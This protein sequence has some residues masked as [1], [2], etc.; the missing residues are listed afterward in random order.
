MNSKKIKEIIKFD[1]E[2][3]IQNKWFM[4]LNIVIF[5]SILF[6]T[7][8]S[9]IENFLDKHDM[10]FME[11]ED[12]TIQVLDNDNILYGELEKHTS[13]IEAIKLEKVTENKYSKDN[14]PADDL[15]LIEAIKDETELIKIKLVSKEGIGSDVYDLI[16]ETVKEARNTLFAAKYNI[17]AEELGTLSSE[18]AIERI[19]LGVDAENSETKEL[20]K[21]VSIVLVYMV[22]IL[23]TSSIANT[24]AQEKTSKSIEYVLTS[25]TAKEYLLAK[26]LGVT[27]TIMVQ[28]LYTGIYYVIGNLIN[29]IIVM[30]SGIV[31]TSGQAVSAISNIDIDI[32]KYVLAMVAYLIFTVFFVALIQATLSS[33]T[34]S[35]SEAGNT[36]TLILFVIIFLYFISLGAITPYTNVSMFMYVISCLPIVSTFFV[37]AMMI[38]GQATTLQIVISFVVLILSVPLVFNICAKYFKNGILDYTSKKK[39]KKLFGKKEEKEQTL[40]EKQEYELKLKFAKRFSF[41]IGMTLILFIFSQTI[42]EMIL[43]IALPTILKDV[44]DSNTILIITT[45]L[46]STISMLI[47]IGFINLYN[48]QEKVKTKTSGKST[49]NLVGVGI[50]LIGLSQ[51]VLPYIYEFFGIN[52]NILESFEVIPGKGFVPGLIFFIVLAVLPAIFEELFCR[53]AILNCA[54]IYGNSFAVIFSAL[55]FAIIHMNFGQAI[56]AFMIGII[57]GV[58]AVKTNSIKIP[59][60]LHLLN[61]GYAALLTI[62]AENQIAIGIINNIVIAILIFSFI[63]LIRNIPSLFKVKRE[64]LKINPDCKLIVR[65]YTFIISVILL[66]V[67]FTATESILKML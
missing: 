2:K 5:I 12:V 14:I 15:I 64:D 49:F 16:Y 53:K 11:M 41:T 6:T 62:F 61:N 58:I 29:S 48:P 67:M 31:Q 7:N 9:H 19:L 18:P 50:A 3:S 45:G 20:I 22:L 36:T 8:W 57:F 65:N 56:F 42:L 27:I 30:N 37:P 43:S 28:V 33:K 51:L 13:E 59:V 55:I 38:I 40:R 25:V 1:V 44:F 35:V 54:K 34:N 46:V 21:M 52:Y 23:V 26:V 32:I 17:T 63:I 66:V 47:S 60:F 39:T 4:I 10:N 24:I